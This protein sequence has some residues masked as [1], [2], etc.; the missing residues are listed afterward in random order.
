[1]SH[2]T[3]TPGNTT[4]ASAP[5]RDG[6]RDRY[7]VGVCHKVLNYVRGLW[8]GRRFRQKGLLQVEGRIRIEVRHGELRTGKSVIWPGAHF[9]LCG[10]SCD[11]PAVFEMGDHCNIGDRAEIHV[12]ERITLG[13]NVII[14]WDC[15][16]MDH[17]YHCLAG[18]KER[19]RPIVIEDDVWIGCRVIIMPGVRI[20]RGSVV[21][22]GSVVTKDV[23]PG[24]LVAGNPARVIREVGG[25][26]H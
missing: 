8:Y 24:M 14:S 3:S 12:A 17:D 26:S 10:I 22:A 21:G 19:I 15:V 13:H 20:G 5:G 7:R 18:D 23:A 1:V 11:R 6:Q 9:S 16:L 4:G 2:L 25:W